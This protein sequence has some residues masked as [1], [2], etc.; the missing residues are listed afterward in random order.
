ML[1]ARAITDVQR[2]LRAS[3]GQF[4]HS[5]VYGTSPGSDV[6]MPLQ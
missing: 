5:R 6:L 2:L 3:Q 1:D 4:S